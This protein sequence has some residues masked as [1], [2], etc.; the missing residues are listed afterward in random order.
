M[1][2]YLYRINQAAKKHSGYLAYLALAFGILFLSVSPI[3]VRKAAAPGVV[4]SF[5]RMFL[6]LAV[7]TPFQLYSLR[8]KETRQQIQFNKRMLLFP[9]AAGFCSAFDHALWADAIN[10]TQVS[11]A[12]LLNSI[13]PIWVSLIAV[14]FLKEKITKKFW[15]G[16]I[17][18]IA[19]I[20]VISGFLSGGLSAGS[21]EGNLLAFVSSFFY[22]GYYSFTEVGRR[23]F[24]TLNQMWISLFFCTL[25]LGITMLA[26]GYSFTGYSRETTLAFITSSLIC[27]LGGYFCLTYALGKLPATLVSPANEIQPILSSIL[28]VFLFGEPFRAPQILGSLAILSG[29]FLINQSKALKENEI[30]EIT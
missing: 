6:T 1:E 14:L 16:L 21:M 8:K 3:L 7:L 26:G 28:A 25:T 15:F 27:Q 12:T 22:A 10:K 20:S 18:V 30:R 13:S 17:L 23:H 2:E 29:L 9:L 4:F 24:S 11:S 5:Y 19:G